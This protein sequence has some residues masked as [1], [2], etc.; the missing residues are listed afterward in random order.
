M[1]F[2]AREKSDIQDVAKALLDSNITNFKVYTTTDEMEKHFGQYLG[3]LDEISAIYDPDAGILLADKCL[4]A[5]WVKPIFFRSCIS[6]IQLF[7][8]LLQK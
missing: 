1:Q 6:H 3:S 7:E 2:G 5:L 4:R 8:N